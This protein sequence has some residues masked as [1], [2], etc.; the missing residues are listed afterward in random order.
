MRRL[1]TWYRSELAAP[2]DAWWGARM[3]ARLPPTTYPMDDALFR[4]RERT[5]DNI[6]RIYAVV[7][8]LSFTN[9][10]RE[11]W[12]YSHLYLTGPVSK[13]FTSG[14]T[15]RLTMLLIFTSTV[16]VFAYQADKFLD[17]RYA[18]RPLDSSLDKR[19]PHW[20][21][22]DF[23]IDAASLILTLIPFTL[24]AYAFNNELIERFGIIPFYFGYV[25]LLNVSVALLFLVRLKY[26]AF[27]SVFEPQPRIRN[28]NGVELLPEET[29]YA[30]LSIHWCITNGLT[31]LLLT[32]AFH[33][34]RSVGTLCGTNLRGPLT[35]F[36]ILFGIS[37]IARNFFDFRAVWPFLYVNKADLV[38]DE[39]TPIMR[40]V[41]R[42][43]L[44]RRP[45][46]ADGLFLVSAVI[47]GVSIGHIGHI[48][49]PTACPK[50]AAA[51]GAP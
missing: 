30:A 44:E 7:Y 45:T 5:V 50:P 6:K 28:Q 51:A 43:P 31:V 26:L 27:L 42:L 41:T 11:I 3:A 15:L 47:I 16:S 14:L 21:R 25:L 9:I 2:L 40:R 37:A 23:A 10:L 19:M 13:H 49:S 46:G 38:S 17:L 12:D 33:V 18:F 4:Q 29:R 8:S 32:V 22:S 34:L 24:M 20:R 36:T 35:I 1:A 48:F 39:L